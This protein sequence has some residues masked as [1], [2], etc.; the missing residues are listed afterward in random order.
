M[1]E[2]L[3]EECHQEDGIAYLPLLSIVEYCPFLKEWC[4]KKM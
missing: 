1:F 3:A 2:G 4:H